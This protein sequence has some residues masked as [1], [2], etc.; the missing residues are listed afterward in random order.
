MAEFVNCG[1]DGCN[2]AEAADICN[3]VG[4]ILRGHSIDAVAL[5]LVMLFEHMAETYPRERASLLAYASDHIADIAAE[6]PR[7]L[8]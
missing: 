6:D 3:A 8:N 7:S 2:E 1:C 4:P 5:A